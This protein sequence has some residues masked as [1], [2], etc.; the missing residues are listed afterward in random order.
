MIRW[1]VQVNDYSPSGVSRPNRKVHM[2]RIK[3]IASSFAFIVTVTVA[4]GISYAS[5]IVY[6]AS[7][8]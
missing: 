8:K 4:V 1:L 5:L 2:I 3:S 6:A 7:T